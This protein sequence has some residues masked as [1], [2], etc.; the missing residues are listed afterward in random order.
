MIDWMQTLAEYYASV[1]AHYPEDELLIVLD[2]DGGLIDGRARQRHALQAFDREHGT[3]WF[4][5]VEPG[6]LGERGC[7]LEQCLHARGLDAQQRA[8]VTLWYRRW[9]QSAEAAAAAGPPRRGI[10]DVL[11]WFQLQPRTEIAIN[12]PRP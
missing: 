5:D 10:M 2:L 1:R 7:D 9:S 11:R 6:E 4:W 12:S 3:G 8:W